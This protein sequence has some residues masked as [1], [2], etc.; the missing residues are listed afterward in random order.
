MRK[1]FS[2]FWA[3]DNGFIIS[4]EMLFIA[5]ILVIGIIGGLAALRAG[6]ATE[7]AKLG[8]A[9]L[10]LDPGFDNVS[11]GSTTSSSD[12]TLT[13]HVDTGLNIGAANAVATNT[14]VGTDVL[15]H[16]APFPLPI[17]P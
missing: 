12:G 8:A 15:G 13:T 16:S 3:D 7:L 17:V 4:V 5:V 6:V 10:N 1:L 9:V 11:V 14:T 2:Q